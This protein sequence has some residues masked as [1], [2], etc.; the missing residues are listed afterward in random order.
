MKKYG[1]SVVADT[2]PGHS[3][4][5]GL[6]LVQRVRPVLD[7]DV[8]AQQR[9]EGV[10]NVS[11]GV[12][13]WVR[14]AQLRINNDAVADIKARGL[15]KFSAGCDANAD[16]HCIRL[17]VTAVRQPDPVGLPVA[18]SDLRNLR[19]GPQVDPVLGMQAG[20]DP[21]NLPAKYAEQ[22]QLG[23]LQHSHLDSGLPGGCRDLQTDPARPDN[24]D[25]ARPGDECLD[26][27]AV[28]GT[29]Q[30]QHAVEV[31]ARHRQLAW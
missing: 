31:C 1:H 15:G 28:G 22:R 29:A 20:E 13:V 9:V 10:G 19:A 17:H 5:R 4:G 16:N 23:R 27:V 26:P 8:L 6:R 18:A 2:L 21:G 7:P 30:V 14:G 25:P 3:P 12:D 24:R 11:G